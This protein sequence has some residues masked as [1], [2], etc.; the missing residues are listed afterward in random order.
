MSSDKQVKNIKKIDVD[1]I[2]IDSFCLT[3][4]I[5]QIDVLKMDIQGGELDAL[6]GAKQMLANG[7]VGLIY[8]ETYFL[9]QYVNQP[10]FHEIATFLHQYGYYLQ[11]V[12]NP[13]YG[14]GN[15]A[16]ADVIFRKK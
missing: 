11:D 13:I 14:N 6:K 16:W 3:N 5:E 15:I 12:Y 1:T 9:E 4:G 8:S 7:K 10:L 2:S